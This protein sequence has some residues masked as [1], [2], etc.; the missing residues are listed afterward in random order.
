MEVG[1]VTSRLQYVAK[2]LSLVKSDL[3]GKT[4]LL[5]FAGS[6]WTLANFM[7]EGGGIKDYL[8]AKALFHAEPQLFSR[9]LEKLTQA[10]TIRSGETTEVKLDF[11]AGAVVMK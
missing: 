5:G 10:V 7:L 6:P 2:A 8:K 4:A 9:L 1:A 3:S 11:A